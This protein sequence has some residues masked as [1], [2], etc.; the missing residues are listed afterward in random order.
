MISSTSTGKTEV[1]GEGTV[2]KIEATNPS[3]VDTSNAGEN[4]PTVDKKDETTTTPTPATKTITAADVAKITLETAV[5]GEK[6]SVT[7]LPTGVTAKGTVWTEATAST[8][9]AQAGETGDGTTGDGT[10]GDGNG[11]NT[12]T[13]GTP[14]TPS[15]T[16][17]Y[18]ATITLTAETGYAFDTAIKKADFTKLS[19]AIEGDVSVSATEIKF[20]VKADIADSTTPPDEKDP[21][22]KITKPADFDLSSWTAQNNTVTINATTVGIADGKEVTWSVTGDA[23]DTDTKFATADSTVTSDATSNTLTIAEGQTP[24]T[25]TITVS[26]G[27]KELGTTTLVLKKEFKGATA[28][29]ETV[30]VD[31]KIG[32]PLTADQ[33]ITVTLAKPANA[34]ASAENPKFKAVTA[35]EAKKWITGLPEGITATA[36]A[37]QENANSVEFTLSGTPTSKT[38]AV[39]IAIPAKLQQLQQM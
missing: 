36:T 15:T 10:T 13:P 38:G 34:D 20:T 31:G 39:A 16:K 4:I 24:T 29:A 3:T 37:I 33:K 1:S 11:G 8:P 18:T 23:I 32:T 28:T 14:E 25:L 26:Y 2:D 30:K 12:E 9:A 19:S 22:I 7:G 35:E 6:A 21:T 5:A 27:G 17:T